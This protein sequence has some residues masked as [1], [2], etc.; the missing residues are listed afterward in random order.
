MFVFF[1]HKNIVNLEKEHHIYSKY[2]NVSPKCKIEEKN[3]NC[4]CFRSDQTLKFIETMYISH[5]VTL[6]LLPSM[7]RKIK[8]NLHNNFCFNTFLLKDTVCRIYC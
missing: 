8:F 5:G 3:E 6:S 4:L 2:K 7:S 1:L